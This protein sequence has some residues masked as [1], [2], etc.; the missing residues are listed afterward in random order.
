AGSLYRGVIGGYQ[1]MWLQPLMMLLG[2][3]M[4]SDIGYVTLAT[5][6]RPFRAINRHISPV[7]GWGWL[8]AATLANLVWAMPQFSLGTAALQ[9]NLGL[10]NTGSRTGTCLA[11]GLLFVVAGGIV[12]LQTAGGRGL[13]VFDWILKGMVAVVV[14]SFFGVVAAM[15]LR[16]DGRPRGEIL[17]NFI[18]NLAL[19]REPADGFRDFIAASGSPDYWRATILAIQRDNMITAAA[20]AVG[21]N[22][23]FLLPYSLLRRGWGR[24][25]TGLATFDL[26]TGL[27]IPFVLATSCVVLAAAAQFHGRYDPGLLGEAE[28]TAITRQLQGGYEANL[29]NRLAAE[30]GVDLVALDAREI[31]ARAAALPRA[32]RQLAAMLVQRDANTLANSLEQLT[33]R[34]V[35]Q[36]VFGVGVLGMAVSTIIILMLINGYTVC[37][38][39]GREPR[40]AVHRLGCLLPGV[41]GALGFLLLWGDANARFWLAVPTSIFGMALLPIA[42]ITFFLMLNSRSLLG[43]H[44]PSGGRR[45]AIN[46]AMLV[47]IAAA[48]TGSLYAIQNRGGT[49]GLAAL[50]VF[51]ALVLGV[52]WLR[53]PAA[54]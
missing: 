14:L 23:T 10:F 41:T 4:L 38:A 8:I 35:A 9:Q 50:G 53:R 32:D 52:Q 16:G 13:R 22:M 36:V 6:E 7:L 40:G 1:F 47:A 49:P 26:A 37:E 34:G 42:Y 17:R 25:F 18:P 33:G 15:S 3:V 19:L 43:E 29:R 54:R 12:G 27:F 39:L 51:V 48:G 20:T 5:G 2:V 28:P 21:I 11:A 45:A 44:R 30:P 31:K 46:A 24:E